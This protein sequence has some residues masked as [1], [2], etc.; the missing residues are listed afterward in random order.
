MKRLIACSIF[1]RVGLAG[2]V[3]RLGNRKRSARLTV[4]TYHRAGPPALELVDAKVVSASAE[5]FDRQVEFCKANFRV[6]AI[7]DVLRFVRGEAPLPPRPLL[8]T[9]DDG[10][11]DNFDVA[12]PILRRHGVPATFFIATAYVGERRLFWWDRIHYL[13]GSATNEVAELTYPHSFTLRLGHGAGDRTAAIA[14]ALR[15]AKDEVGLDMQRFLDHLGDKAGVLADPARERALVDAHLMTWEHVRAL[16]RGGMDV[17][18]HTHTHRVLHTLPRDA[19]VTDLVTAREILEDVLGHPVRAVAYPVGKAAVYAEDTRRAVRDAGYEIGF[20]NR[21]GV[22]PLHAVDAFD[23]KR[24]PI[25]ASFT[26]D[27]F[28]SVLA[29]PALAYPA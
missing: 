7:D 4:L 12:Y 9:L 27:Y 8:I 2:A 20:S 5:T 26:E 21:N 17:Q 3:L 18:S 13:V 23:L 14:R 15:I 6:V 10:Y 25:D 28:E 24:I 22:N 19:L 29:L 1:A 16:R 11:L